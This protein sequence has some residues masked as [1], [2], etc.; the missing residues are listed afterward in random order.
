MGKES[1]LIVVSEEFT[2]DTQI[3]NFPEADKNDSDNWSDFEGEVVVGIYQSASLE[4]AIKDAAINLGVS[5]EM[6]E[7]YKLK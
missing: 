6:L 1:F 7:G 2:R 5:R 4:N 3:A